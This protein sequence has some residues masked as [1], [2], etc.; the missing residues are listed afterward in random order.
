MRRV[1]VFFF[2]AAGLI[3]SNYLY[4]A[5]TVEPNWAAATERSFFQAVALLTMWVSLGIEGINRSR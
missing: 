3:T 1:V 4:Q 2:V 5:A